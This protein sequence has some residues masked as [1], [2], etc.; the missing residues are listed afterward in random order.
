MSGELLIDRC[1]VTGVTSISNLGPFWSID[2]IVALGLGGRKQGQETI[3]RLLSWGESIMGIPWLLLHKNPLDLLTSRS[4]HLTLRTLT[5][6]P[7]CGQQLWASCQDSPH[8]HQRP[9]EM[10]GHVLR[11]VKSW[12]QEAWEASSC[13]LATLCYHPGCWNVGS[14]KGKGNTDL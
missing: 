3:D 13:L 6:H 9:W 12:E 4:T 5:D 8:C 11:E 2:F 7:Q 14:L 1:G 10:P